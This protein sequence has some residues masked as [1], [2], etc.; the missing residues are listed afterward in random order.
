MTSVATPSVVTPSVVTPSVAAAPEPSGVRRPTTRE[1][2]MCRPD[3]FDVHY[4]INPWM[5]ATT[6]VDRALALAQ[7]ETLRATYEEHGHRVHVVDGVAGLP[8]MVFAANGGLVIGDRALSAR[9]ANPERALEGPAYHE[10]MCAQPFASVAAAGETNEGEG[11]FA[12]A[13]DRI[14]AGTGFRSS[15]AA[16]REVA[17][18]FGLPVVTL[19]LV[20]P[21][22]YH[23]DTALM[24]LD[25]TIVYYPAAFSGAS[26]RLLAQLYPDAV[27]ATAEDANVL[28]LNGVSDGYHVFLSDR[29][30]GLSEQLRL[31]GYD[32]IGV[33]LSELLKA[34]GS[35]KCCTLELHGVR[36][37]AEPSMG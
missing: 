5:D 35:V 3:H 10:W 24:V 19:E 21:R 22:F 12:I 4:A 36:T 14:L 7:W 29:A 2:L 30:V 6:P 13:R 31:R 20:D 8:D 33:D 11:D 9:F 26:A 27:I 18:F 32:T 23:L 25:E 34:G 15:R 17:E 1:F 16:H 37:A 28:G